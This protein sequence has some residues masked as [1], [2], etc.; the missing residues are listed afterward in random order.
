MILFAV[1][2]ASRELAVVKEV[3]VLHE[4]L[5]D[6]AETL[7][8]PGTPLEASALAQALSTEARPV[9]PFPA[10]GGEEMVLPGFAAPLPRGELEAS[11]INEQ[12]GYLESPEG[13]VAWAAVPLPGSEDMLLVAHRH[14]PPTGATL[15][16]VYQNRLIIPA[17]FY[18]W[19]A[20]WVSLI[21]NSLVTRLRLQKDE[22]ER[23]AWYDA[24]T[25]LPNRNLLFKRL[26]ELVEGGTGEGASLSLAVVDLDG[27]K[28]V[29]DTFGHH[30]GDELL[31]QVAERFRRVVRRGDLVARTGGDEFVL[32]LTDH[33]PRA[34][35]AVC[36]RILEALSEPYAL[37]DRS[38]AVGASLGL[39]RYPHDG[40]DT[41]VLT[42]KADQAMYEAK[43]S[44]GGIVCYSG[45][46]PVPVGA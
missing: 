4:L 11:R 22:L 27:F 2:N 17:L 6:R 7:A 15:L 39:A 44:G 10:D 1:Y 13:P 41:A 23:M 12:G 35:E 14:R 5:R 37:P 30:A 18:L 43:R 29:N 21:L 28:Q 26:D 33:D 36:E 46:D 42:R 19:A 45:G 34:C 25:G 16:S 3:E 24:L 9:L 31:R 8:A 38:I 32:L 20:V 40:R